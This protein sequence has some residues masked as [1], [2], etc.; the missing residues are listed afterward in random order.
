M[1]SHYRGPEDERRALS[2]FIAITRA[3]DGYQRRAFEYAPL[4][5][6]LT[7]SQFAVLEA[8]LHLGPMSQTAVA[9]KVM[10]TKGNITVVVDNLVKAGYL[11]RHPTPDDRRLSIIDLTEAGRKCIADYFPRIAGG[12]AA[13]AA[14]LSK[15]EQETLT[16]L[17]KKL[18]RPDYA[19]STSG[20]K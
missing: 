2:L 16:S 1:P 13:A 6:G 20:S 3:S 19:G 8:L 9:R 18:G 5:E 12:F 10:K 14:D 15:E 4:P 11:V 7:L 17:A